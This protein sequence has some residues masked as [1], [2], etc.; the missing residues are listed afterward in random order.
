MSGR[1]SRLPR[2]AKQE[3][4]LKAIDERI[5]TREEQIVEARPQGVFMHDTRS[6]SRGIHQR[7]GEHVPADDFRW[8]MRMR[9]CAGMTSSRWGS[10]SVHRMPLSVFHQ[11]KQELPERCQVGLLGI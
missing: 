10:V 7:F 8:S 4:C 11:G 5:V 6:R 3:V 1:Q 9:P 2:L